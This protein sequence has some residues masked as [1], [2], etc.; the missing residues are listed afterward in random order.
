MTS[1]SAASAWGS[2]H[3]RGGTADVTAAQ[4]S[5]LKVRKLLQHIDVKDRHV[6]SHQLDQQGLSSPV[7]SMRQ[8]IL[9]PEL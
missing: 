5:Q 2:L 9:H 3:T 1:Q 6:V 8:D 4:P 7:R